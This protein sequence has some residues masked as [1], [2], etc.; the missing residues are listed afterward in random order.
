MT[1]D[2]NTIFFDYWK[3]IDNEIRRFFFQITSYSKYWCLLWKKGFNSH[4]SV[5]HR[6]YVKLKKYRISTCP[7]DFHR[8]NKKWWL[9]KSH[10]FI[11]TSYTNQYLIYFLS[12]EYV[13]DHRLFNS[14]YGKD[15]WRKRYEIECIMNHFCWIQI[16]YSKIQ[17]YDESS[18]QISRHVS[19]KYIG[20][21]FWF[22]NS[23]TQWD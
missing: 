18:R 19:H 5:P 11:N 2:S 4:W 20:S 16:T 7:D 21:Q 8:K 12:S 23:T 14:F 10:H 3:K 9:L 1:S 17:Y 22:L 15:D 6:K 13:W